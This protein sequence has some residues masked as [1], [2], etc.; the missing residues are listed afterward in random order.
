MM[1]GSHSKA[2]L[3]LTIRALSGGWVVSTQVTPDG[4]E[5]LEGGEKILTSMRSLISEVES[6]GDSFASLISH[7]MA[8]VK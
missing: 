3:I 4:F 6:Q 2:Q 8:E 5:V 1:A 7:I